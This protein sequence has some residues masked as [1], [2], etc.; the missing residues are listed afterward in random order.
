M[1]HRLGVRGVAPTV[2]TLSRAGTATRIPTIMCR[3]LL[4][5]G[6]PG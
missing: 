3:T 1:V 4:S 6:L 5:M 2:I